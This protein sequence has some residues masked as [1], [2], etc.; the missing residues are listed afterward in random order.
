MAVFIAQHTY[1]MPVAGTIKL[2]GGWRLRVGFR[3]SLP[4]CLAGG[5]KVEALEKRKKHESTD[6]SICAIIYFQQTN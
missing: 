2:C 1:N 6:R 4:A 3:A 5:Q